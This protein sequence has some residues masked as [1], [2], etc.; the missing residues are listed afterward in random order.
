MRIE[1]HEITTT[2]PG[3]FF[4]RK[5]IFDL[6]RLGDVDLKTFNR[7]IGKSALGVDMDRD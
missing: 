1:H 2:P 5:Q 4:T 6:V 7:N 3:E